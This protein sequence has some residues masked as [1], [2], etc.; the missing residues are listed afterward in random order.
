MMREC[1]RCSGLPDGVCR[2][3]VIIAPASSGVT[4][5]YPMCRTRPGLLQVFPTGLCAPGLTRPMFQ[6]VFD[7]P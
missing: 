5:W 3:H 1:D 7:L 4:S 6:F 2:S